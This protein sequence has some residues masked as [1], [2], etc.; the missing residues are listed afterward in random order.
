[1]ARFPHVCRDCK[2]PKR[3]VNCHTSCWAYLE[4]KAEHEA[5]ADQERKT[6][7]ADEDAKGVVFRM[8]RN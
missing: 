6:K 7:K 1:M 4:A 2:P 5:R 3:S 8:K